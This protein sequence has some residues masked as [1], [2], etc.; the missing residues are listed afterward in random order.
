MKNFSISSTDT[1]GFSKIMQTF[2]QKFEEANSFSF[3]LLTLLAKKKRARM[4]K[5]A[6]AIKRFF[7]QRHRL[8]I[9]K[10]RE[11]C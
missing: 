6:A 11:L 10:L 3:K 4:K 5:K 7:T 1:K 9:V 8:L 2:E